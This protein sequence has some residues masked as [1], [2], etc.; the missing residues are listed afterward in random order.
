IQERWTS[1]MYAFFDPDPTLEEEGGR[2]YV[3]FKCLGKNCRQI[4]RRYLDTSDSMLTGGLRKH[5]ISCW[6]KEVLKRAS[7]ADDI[8]QA[9][10]KV[11]IPYRKSGTLTTA[12]AWKG[13]GKP[14]YSTR[15]LN[16]IQTK[17]EIVRWICEDKRPMKIVKDRGFLR[18]MKSGRPD[19]Y[20]PS[21]STVSR[22]VKQVFV[23]TR[24]RIAQM[25]Q[26]SESRIS[27]QMDAWTSPNH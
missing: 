21:P 19:Y 6:G 22:D 26:Q 13:K 4:K 15:Q 27:L 16:R 10:D 25:L 18:L 2:K 3:A 24:S 14:T 7:A 5:V 20:V 11:I 17:T 1:I 8:A 9:R 12:F 23:K